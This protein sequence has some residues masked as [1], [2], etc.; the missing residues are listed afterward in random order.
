MIHTNRTNR[1]HLRKKA[2]FSRAQTP[3][4]MKVGVLRLGDGSASE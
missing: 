2:Q 4:A 1:A 3:Q